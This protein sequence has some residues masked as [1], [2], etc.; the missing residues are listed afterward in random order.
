MESN[1]AVDRLEKIFPRLKGGHNYTEPSQELVDLAEV[2]MSKDITSFQEWFGL[3]WKL[4]KLRV[5]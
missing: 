4:L 1:P 2:I 5:K 3:R